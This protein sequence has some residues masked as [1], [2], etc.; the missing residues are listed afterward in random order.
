VLTT[1]IGDSYSL[2]FYVLPGADSA[3]YGAFSFQQFLNG[4]QGI[5]TTSVAPLG[6]WSL[7]TTSFTGTGADAL[8]FRGYD[9]ADYYY[10]DD[11]SVTDLSTNG[12]GCTVESDNCESDVPEPGTF[13]LL[14]CAFA[15]AAA[16][17]RRFLRA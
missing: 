13:G 17:S 7:F 16:T 9:A 10:L 3:D 11:V 8:M 12:G 6:V 1:N 14:G 4:V 15:L 2:Q 5:D